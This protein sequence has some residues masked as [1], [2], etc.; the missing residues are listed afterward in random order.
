MLWVIQRQLRSGNPARRRQGIEQLAAKPHL[1]ALAALE[2]ILQ[3]DADAENRRL[4]AGAVA[5]A[6]SEQTMEILLRALN[7]QDEEVVKAAV[8]GL[9][10]FAEPRVDGLVAAL[11]R[12]R[13]VGVRGQAA[14]TLENHAW[15]PENR[16]DEIWFL[17]AKGQL[18][19]LGSYGAAALPALELTL[20]ASGVKA[21]VA[22]VETLGQ[23]RDPRAGRLLAQAARSPDP[24]I[25]VAAVQTLSRH[26][27][28][29]ALEPLIL[30]L[31]HPHAQVRASTVEELG[32][33]RLAQAAPAVRALLTDPAWEVRL[34]AVA[35][36]GRLRDAD[37]VEALARLLN[38]EDGDVREASAM[39]LGNL[40]DRRAI[41][42]LV[43]ALRDS[44]SGVRR[45]AAAALSRIDSAWNSSPEARAA[46]E[47]LRSALTDEDPAVRY[48]VG[49]LL[50]GLGT[51]TSGELAGGSESSFI[52][53]PEKRRKLA[54]SLFLAVLCDPD[55]DLRQA[56]AEALGQLGD[57][58]AC[59]A[60]ERAQADAD[61]GVARAA[62]AALQAVQAGAAEGGGWSAPVTNPPII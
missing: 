12:H 52:T 36:L 28:E 58:R 21:T 62:A 17:A 44:A 33:K 22:A 35:A 34:E 61:A 38:D 15:R 16:D 4:A 3:H 47:Q 40:G 26:G 32:R 43:L 45:L 56:A 51:I 55:V 14:N 10:R 29:Q 1:G 8:L 20:R 11:L 19:R 9:R 30:A 2:T 25:A 41:G 39:T 37:S 24:G 27:D 54:V 49:Q 23:I 53:S 6:E 57:D 60:L 18:S 7:H 50:V 48:S 5:K 46:G 42:P 59:S 13:D 31:S